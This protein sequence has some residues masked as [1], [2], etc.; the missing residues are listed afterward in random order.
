MIV[1][2]VDGGLGSQMWQYSLGRLAAMKSGLP[3]C[4]DLSW[5]ERDGMDINK[6]YSRAY[7]LETVFPNVRLEN[8]DAK[9]A[10]TYRKYFNLYPGTRRDYD[11]KVIAS[12]NARY[13]GGYYVNAKYVDLQGDALRDE[14]TFGIELSDGNGKVRSAI[15]STPQAV[16]IHIRRGD[17]VGSVHDVTTPKYFT[18]AVKFIAAKLSPEKAVFFVFSN[19]MEWSRKILE[20]LDEKFVFVENNDNDSGEADMFLM[21]RCAHF[22]ISNSSFSWWPAWL[23]RRSADKIVVAPNVWLSGERVSDRL[24]MLSEGWLAMPA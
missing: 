19:G 2:L 5:F 8:A 13:I 18:D 24:S 21:S 1:V 23:S 7:R 22:V 16:A 12:R 3:V 17:Y 20:G 10:E 6:K 4:Y 15:E 11:E 14:L 9:T